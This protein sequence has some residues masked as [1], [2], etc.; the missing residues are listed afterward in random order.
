[1]SCFAA[2]FAYSYGTA[3]NCIQWIRESCMFSVLAPGGGWTPATLDTCVAGRS[4]LACSDF[5]RGNNYP[6]ACYPTGPTQ[7]GQTCIFG[8]Q[9]ASGYC[10]K[11]NDKNC[12]T[13]VPRAIKNASCNTTADCVVGLACAKNGTCQ[14]PV[15]A[16][17][18]CDDARPCQNNLYCKGQQPNMPGICTA[19]G[20]PN[21][22]C[23][24]TLNG[25]DCD[26]F[27]FAWCVA[28][29]K[30]CGSYLT[31]D[32]GQ[33]CGNL[34]PGQYTLCKAKSG[35]VNG[36]CVAAN[37]VGS[38]CDPSIGINCKR[39]SQCT[40]KKCVAPSYACD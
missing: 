12:G 21:D 24:P 7:D 23:D 35:C 13:C 15:F 26:Y 22:A 3:Q 6:S 19:P 5:L 9:C 1:E 29:S 40:M 20:G 28:S 39:T 10:K 36:N 11:A 33:P 30:Q 34:A 31:A 32:D 16:K 14:P 25:V 27:Q 2:G 17:E 4:A 37:D 38:T 8:H 18:A